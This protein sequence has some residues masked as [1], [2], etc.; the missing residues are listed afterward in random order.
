MSLLHQRKFKICVPVF[1]LKITWQPLS[2][3]P[4]LTINNCL[5]LNEW[6]TNIKTCSNSNKR[7][8]KFYSQIHQWGY[9][10]CP[11]SKK[12]KR[13]YKLIDVSCLFETQYP[14]NNM[15]QWTHS[16]WEADSI[17]LDATAYDSQ[18]N[19]L[20]QQK[21]YQQI[22]FGKRLNIVHE[23]KLPLATNDC[24]CPLKKLNSYKLR[25]IHFHHILFLPLLF[26]CAS[27]L[28]MYQ[29]HA[30]LQ[31]TEHRTQTHSRRCPFFFTQHTTEF[32]KESWIRR[33]L[34]MVFIK[35]AKEA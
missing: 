23:P 6:F 28:S 25:R 4:I 34:S 33:I 29:Q 13:Q 35:M 9:F 17:I 1:Q 10:N 27:D 11:A 18:I 5:A 20:V 24:T 31:D 21:R 15:N 3:D 7:K 2:N 12:L 32:Q 22:Q 30:H 26:I 8:Q 19:D 16:S 14:A